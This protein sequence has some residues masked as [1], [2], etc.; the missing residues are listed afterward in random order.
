MPRRR[1]TEVFSLSFLDCMCC[2]F[3]ALVLFYTV[4]SAQSGVE[5]VR[6]NEDLA[7]EINLLEEE[8]LEGYKNL[9]VLRNTLEKT[10][11][12]RVQA[13]GRLAQLLQELERSRLEM[14]SSSGDS[15]ARR[16]HIAKLKADIRSLEEGTR[17]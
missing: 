4:I 17:R 8:V 10:D 11:L 6:R 15:L 5:R 9:V 3:G 1:D 14:A 7:A 12:A 13:S 16:E 2:G